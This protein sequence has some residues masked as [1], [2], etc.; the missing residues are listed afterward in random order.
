[1]IK[2]AEGCQSIRCRFDVAWKEKWKIFKL[3]TLPNE[4]VLWLKI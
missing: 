1:M 4:V 3:P 2:A